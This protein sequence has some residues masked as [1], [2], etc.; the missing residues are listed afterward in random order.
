MIK[1]YNITTAQILCFH[2]YNAC[3]T[4]IKRWNINGADTSRNVSLISGGCSLPALKSLRSEDVS[5]SKEK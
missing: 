3:G 2:M 4:T 1:T 5:L